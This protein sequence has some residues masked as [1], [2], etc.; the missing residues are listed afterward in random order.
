MDNLYITRSPNI[1]NKDDEE[2]RQILNDL[3]EPITEGDRSLSSD[4]LGEA[5]SGELSDHNNTS[6]N[7]TQSPNCVPFSR[8]LEPSHDRSTS[9][10]P[11]AVTS[12]IA[13]LL[14]DE[15]TS[16]DVEIFKL[17]QQVEALQ[18]EVERLLVE[19]AQLREEN[20]KRTSTDDSTS[21]IQMLIN[22]SKA[23]RV[24]ERQRYSNLITQLGQLES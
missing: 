7:Y 1:G 3:P 22:R 17:Q 20:S 11:A 12:A 23:E 13:N 15:E 19:N 9:S 18:T 21:K 5:P 2:I 16:P 14:S 6:L 10:A 24:K 4:S 8:F